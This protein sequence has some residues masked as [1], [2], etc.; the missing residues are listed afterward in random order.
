MYLS[1]N[2]PKAAK[3]VSWM[4]NFF[5]DDVPSKLHQLFYS[6]TPGPG[7]FFAT[8]FESHVNIGPCH[9]SGNFLPFKGKSHLLSSQ[10]ARFFSFAKGKKIPFAKES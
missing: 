3:I 9:V 4:N 5:M 1:S 6:S 8:I 7:R 2:S 10:A